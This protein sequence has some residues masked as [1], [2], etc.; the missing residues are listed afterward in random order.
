MYKTCNSPDKARDHL[1]QATENS[2]FGDAIWAWK[3][4]QELPDFD[5]DSAK[6]NVRR[7]LEQA[8]DG[9]ESSS[10][11]G[12]WLYNVAM[13]DSA[14]GN[15][16]EAEKEFLEALLSTDSLMSYHLTRLAMRDGL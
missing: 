10:P 12:W 11:S 7:I 13:L 14:A 8:R 16:R 9:L 1:I 6:Q 4:S 3:A 2:S 15:D 5:A